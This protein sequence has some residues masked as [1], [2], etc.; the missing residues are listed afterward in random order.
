MTR[1][2][3]PYDRESALA[4]RFPPAALLG[5][6][7]VHLFIGWL[8]LFFLPAW[9]ASRE[10]RAD[11]IITVQLLG[12]LM[13]AAPAAPADLPVNPDRKGPDIVETP[14]SPPEPTTPS[15]KPEPQ[16]VAAPEELIPL[17]PKAPEKAPE[18]KKN[19]A[20][21][22]KVQAPKVEKPK[23]KPNIDAEINRRLRNLERKVEA[24]NLDADIE[25]RMMN[26]AKAQ[27]QGQGEGS[28]SG[29]ASQGQLIDPEKMRYYERIKDIISS[30]WV[31]PAG[32]SA[33]E[34]LTVFQIRIEPDGRIS[35]SHPLQSSGDAEFDLSVERAIRKSSPFP[36]LP[37][38]FGGQADNPALRFSDRELRSIAVP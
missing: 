3:S 13:P 35:T 27:G 31:P 1:L 22:P 36:P 5:S 2:I 26:L 8:F 24:E 37:A 12:S 38:V 15:P 25:A 30:N 11:D 33:T 32:A 34:L 4:D 18:L 9:H 19:S 7:A 21:P 10:P 14:P 29:G 20:E 6:L 17:G 23:P 28:R 16:T